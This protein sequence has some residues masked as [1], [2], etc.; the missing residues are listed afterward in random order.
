MINKRFYMETL[1]IVVKEEMRRQHMA[2]HARRLE[3]M[4]RADRN[5]DNRRRRSPRK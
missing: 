1:Q 5:R 2:E 4:R 3:E